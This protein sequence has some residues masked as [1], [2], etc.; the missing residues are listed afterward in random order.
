MKQAYDELRYVECKNAVCS[1]S[2]SLPDRTLLEP[3]AYHLTK[4]AVFPPVYFA[5]LRCGH[6][7]GYIPS[8][9]RNHGAGHMLDQDPARELRHRAVEL[10]CGTGCKAPATIHIPTYL[11]GDEEALRTHV[12]QLTLVEVFCKHGQRIETVLPLDPYILR[13]S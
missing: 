1:E 13:Y 7:Y 4:G 10:L 5:C 3:T 2:I 8:E 6:V 9:A 12:S 11:D